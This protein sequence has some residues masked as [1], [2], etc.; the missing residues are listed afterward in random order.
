[1]TRQLTANMLWLCIDELNEEKMKGKMYSIMQ[2]HPICFHDFDQMI[3]KADALFD[4]I[5]Y[6][7]SFQKKRTLNEYKKTQKKYHYLNQYPQMSSEDI[8]K[9]NGKKATFAVM[10]NTRQYTNWQGFVL[11]KDLNRITDFD[12]VLQLLDIMI[13]I[14]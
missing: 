5:G 10:V 2:A 14:I 13:H 7:Q 9:Q 12:D 8:M 6:P 11:Q 3:L 4:N 1:M